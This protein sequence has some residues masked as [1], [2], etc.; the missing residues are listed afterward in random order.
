M[1]FKT[2]VVSATYVY[3]IFDD[4]IGRIAEKGFGLI[5]FRTGYFEDLI[6]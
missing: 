6:R 5:G 1:G 2:G 4:S 3:D